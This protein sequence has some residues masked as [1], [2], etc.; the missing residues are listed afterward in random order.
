MA[1]LNPTD[2]RPDMP[3]AARDGNDGDAGF[4]FPRLS[5]AGASVALSVAVFLIVVAAGVSYDRAHRFRAQQAAAPDMASGGAILNGVH[6]PSPSLMAGLANGTSRVLLA[7]ARDCAR[8]QQW[9]CVDESTHAA[10]ALDSNE[11]PVSAMQALVDR[12]A[13]SAPL[14]AA[15]PGYGARH[16]ARNDTMGTM[17]VVEHTHGKHHHHHPYAARTARSTTAAT[18]RTSPE[19]F[20]DIYRH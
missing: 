5:R 1:R 9:D 2:D 10:L 16:G 14:M 4:G 3:R 11:Q 18:R 19:V 12:N 7:Q 13:A 6:A 8:A 15:E 20:A 17:K